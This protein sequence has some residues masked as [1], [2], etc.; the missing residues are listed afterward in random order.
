MAKR[1][2]KG[3]GVGPR[4]E[5]LLELKLGLNASIY[6]FP[7]YT[8][9][10]TKVFK[11]GL[12]LFKVEMSQSK[13]EQ[14]L[15]LTRSRGV[16]SPKDFKVTKSAMPLSGCC[17]VLASPNTRILTFSKVRRCFLFGETNLTDLPKI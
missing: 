6:S 3:I 13:L 4:E 14:A 1:E 8:I 12:N 11:L 5:L 7:R 9:I 17:I 15:Q 10:S 16:V 2:A